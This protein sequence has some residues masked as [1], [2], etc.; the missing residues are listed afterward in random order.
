MDFFITNRCRLG[1]NVLRTLILFVMYFSFS[2]V[3]ATELD[4]L[5]DYNVVWDSQSENSAGS[6]PCG[7]HDI[8][9]NV[10][11]E[12]DDILFY[13]QRSGSIAENNEYLKLG[14]IRVRM[15]PNP[16]TEGHFKQTLN[17]QQGLVEIQGSKTYQGK[18]LTVNM[19]VWVEALRPIIHVEIDANQDIEVDVAYENWRLAEEVLPNNQRRHSVYVFDSYPG[20]ITLSGDT[21]EQTDDGVVFYHRNPNNKQIKATMVCSAV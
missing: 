2:A 16:F 21:I 3:L 20:I 8:G 5:D 1:F 19:K 12:N 7:G 18:A 13:M 11:A 17:L 15:T 10:W 6:M 14:R 9:L 4:W